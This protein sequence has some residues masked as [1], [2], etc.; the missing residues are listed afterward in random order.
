MDKL[1][2]KKDLAERWQVS[3]ATIDRWVS[4]KIITPVKGIPSIRFN[5]HHILELEGVKIERLSPLERKRL[6][7]DIQELKDRIVELEKEN[8]ELK[9]Y[10]RNIFA[11]AARFIDL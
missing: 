6:E 5:P 2:T 3:I 9:E 8:I 10:I 11:G 1:L 4:D 7:K